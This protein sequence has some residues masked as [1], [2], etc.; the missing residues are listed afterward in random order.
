MGN[1][2]GL[3]L[4]AFC[5]AIDS[6]ID[7]I[8]LVRPTSV[9]I[10]FDLPKLC[11]FVNPKDLKRVAS[12]SIHWEGDSVS[13]PTVTFSSL[14]NFNLAGL[15]VIVL[16]LF[17]QKFHAILAYSRPNNLA[18]DLVR[19]PGGGGGSHIDMVYVYVLLPFGALFREIWYSDRGV[20]IR[21]EG[22]Q[23]T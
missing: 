5:C 14:W 1:N 13:T 7:S 22:A 18:D 16:H 4:I 11:K 17:F 8:R 12:I 23:I 19:A 3:I 20:F 10:S 9:T 6:G 15:I 2:V 21:D